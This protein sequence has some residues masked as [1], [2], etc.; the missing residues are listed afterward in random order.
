M[1]HS[2]NYHNA[3]RAKQPAGSLMEPSEGG[4]GEAGQQ[5]WPGKKP[6]RCWWQLWTFCWGCNA[7]FPLFHVCV[8]AYVYAALCVYDTLADINDACHQSAQWRRGKG[9][10]GRGPSLPVVK[11]FSASATHQSQHQLSVWEWYRGRIEKGGGILAERRVL[12]SHQL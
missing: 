3:R 8:C 7:A 9:G 1:A 11:P 12:I 2:S 10:Y 6:M 4:K 5:H